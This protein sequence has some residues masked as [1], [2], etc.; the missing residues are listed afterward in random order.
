MSDIDGHAS[1]GDGPC[2]EKLKPTVL[3]VDD[4]KAIREDISVLLTSN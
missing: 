2:D 1:A 4:A 3:I